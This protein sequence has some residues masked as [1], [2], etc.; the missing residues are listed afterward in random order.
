MN[1][2][3][4]QTELSEITQNQKGQTLYVLIVKLILAK[5]LEYP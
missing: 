1:L 3:G 4:K 2:A 5:R